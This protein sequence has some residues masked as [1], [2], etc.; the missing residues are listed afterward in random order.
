MVQKT[1]P[2][3]GNVLA[4]PL[5]RLNQVSIYITEILLQD[6]FICMWSVFNLLH[7]KE[8]AS[9]LMSVAS[10]SLHILSHSDFRFWIEHIALES[11]ADRGQPGR[12]FLGSTGARLLF[13]HSPQQATTKYSH[14]SGQRASS[15]PASGHRRAR[16]FTVAVIRASGR[17]WL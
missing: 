6:Q 3:Q 10:S 5:T 7:N 1:G 15:P 16:S 2:S 8:L 9:L 11:K 14:T 13:E 4:T 12:T 17:G